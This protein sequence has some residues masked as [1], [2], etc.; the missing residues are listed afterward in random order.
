MKTVKHVYTLTNWCLVLSTQCLA[1]CADAAYETLID[2]TTFTKGVEY[3]IGAGNYAA[4]YADEQCVT[5]ADGVT[6]Y[7]DPGKQE[8][9]NSGW[10]T[11]NI[12]PIVG[13]VTNWY[14][15]DFELVMAGAPKGRDGNNIAINLTDAN[16]E[17]Y[18][19]DP[20]RQYMEDGDLH[21]VYRNSHGRNAS[22]HWGGDGDGVVQPPMSFTAVNVHFTG[23]AA[24]IGEVTFRKVVSLDDSDVRRD[25][26]VIEP[27]SLDTTFPGAAPFTGPFRLDF[28]TNKPYNGGTVLYLYEESDHYVTFGKATNLYEKMSSDSITFNLDLDPS[29][30]YHYY[31]LDISSTCYPTNCIGYF[32]QTESE[33][34][35]LEVDTGN[36]LH[37]CRDE[38][39]RPTLLIRNPSV[40]NLH[41]KTEFVVSDTFER[42]FRIPFDRTVEPGEMVRVDLPWPL[43]AMGVWYVNAR[44]AGDDGSMAVKTTQFAWIPRHE[45]TPRMDRS[46]FRFGIHNHGTRY[47]PN[48]TDKFISALVA[49]GAKFPRTDYSFMFGD[50]CPYRSVFE[51]SVSKWYWEKPDLLLDKLVEAGLSTEI[52]IYSAPSWAQDPNA[53]WNQSEAGRTASRSGCRPMIEGVFEK[54]CEEF[55]RHYAGKI[56]YYEV[57]NEWDIVPRVTLSHEEGLRM[58]KEA[59]TGLHKGDPNACVCPNGWAG[60]GVSYNESNYNDPNYNWGLSETISDHPEY[61]D[62]WLIHVHSN[63]EIYSNMIDAYLLP[64]LNGKLKGVKPWVSGESAITSA[65]GNEYSQGVHVWYK[66]LFAWNRG[67][68]DYI[69]Y[70]LKATG[71]FDGGEPGFGLVSADYHPRAGYAAF[72]ALTD[73]FEGLDADGTVHELDKRKIFR[74]R[75]KNLKDTIDGIV[76]AGWDR[77]TD[78]EWA[79]QIATDAKRAEMSD[80]MGN[81]TETEIRDGVVLF[82]GAFAPRALILQDATYARLANSCMSDKSVATEFTGRHWYVDGEN[83]QRGDGSRE[84]PFSTIQSAVA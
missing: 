68:R 40:T 10:F 72:A 79:M 62:A 58:Q 59:Y 74:Y 41:W 42:S 81:R 3:T 56:D 7:S 54:F 14:E 17:T 71:W 4:K 55:G 75:G 28:K 30:H 52:I 50:V 21:L 80:H 2:F 51:N 38:S 66:T 60:V 39:E 46:K 11:M 34:M 13:A 15:R 23:I 18:Q 1:F 24:S 5:S 19:Y 49:A 57:G 44:V 25:V 9:P 29:R 61:F 83:R 70:N 69:W 63:F 27:V 47:M 6:V 76:L 33:A 65:Y 16:G 77:S 20:S 35:R 78:R 82:R 8:N 43:P 64:M 67:A 48:E 36:D 73:I 84:N 12:R 32:R 31:K 53:T 45:V 26:V 37:I 22:G